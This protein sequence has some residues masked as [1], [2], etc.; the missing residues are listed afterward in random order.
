ME[1]STSFTMCLI[2]PPFAKGD[3]GGFSLRQ[4]AGVWEYGWLVSMASPASHVAKR[5]NLLQKEREKP[6]SGGFFC[7]I[8]WTLRKI[9]Q[10]VGILY[11]I[12]STASHS[13]IY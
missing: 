2:L 5:N 11:K 3:R 1:L 10:N 6:P 12:D 4:A 9:T 8:T 13:L 7:F